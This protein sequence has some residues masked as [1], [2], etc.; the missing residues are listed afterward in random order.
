MLNTIIIVIMITSSLAIDR[1]SQGKQRKEKLN[2]MEIYMGTLR[3]MK[4]V[5]LVVCCV[6]LF[7]RFPGIS[8]TQKVGC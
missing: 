4:I 7:A 3:H 5:A 6:C 2:P 8:E 1:H